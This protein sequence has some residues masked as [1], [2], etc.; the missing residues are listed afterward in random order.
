MNGTNGTECDAVSGQCNCL[1]NVVGRTC[2][3][4]EVSSTKSCESI[5]ILKT[6]TV[7]TG[8]CCVIFQI[9]YYGL[10]S[11][12]DC[13]DCTCNETGSLSLQ[14]RENGQCVCKFGVGGEHCDQCEPGYFGF[15][16]NGCKGISVP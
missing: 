7:V 15:N 9:N 16:E 12:E 11:G 2:D 1:A 14:C 13:K 10:T 3:A 4:C 6:R 8:N 5:C